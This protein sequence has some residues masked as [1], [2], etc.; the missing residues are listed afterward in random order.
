MRANSIILSRNT[1]ID[2]V[3]VLYL[4]AVGRLVS[5]P[6]YVYYGTFAKLF[7]NCFYEHIEEIYSSCF[8]NEYGEKI[9]PL[10]IEECKLAPIISDFFIRFYLP[11]ELKDATQ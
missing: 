3:L 6:L 8:Q 2:T 5:E 11:V 9:P 10:N 1:P 4:L 7:R